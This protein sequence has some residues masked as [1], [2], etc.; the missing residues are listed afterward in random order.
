MVLIQRHNPRLRTRG[1]TKNA[2]ISTAQ[3]IRLAFWGL[4]VLSLLLA[5]YL[6][7][8]VGTASNPVNQTEGPPPVSAMNKPVKNNNNAGVVHMAHEPDHDHFPNHNNAPHAKPNLRNPLVN[9]QKIPAKRVHE[10]D[11]RDSKSMPHN[12]PA[13][14]HDHHDEEHEWAQQ[15]Q[16]QATPSPTQSP[17][18]KLPEKNPDPI[19]PKPDMSA[20]NAVVVD[21]QGS[22]PTHL[23]Y[24]K[25][26]EFERAHPAI[27]ESAAAAV[28]T[29]AAEHMQEMS[30]LAETPLQSC[31]TEDGTL[32]PLC[33]DSDT[34]LYAYN[35]ADFSRTICD[36]EVEPHKLV[37]LDS[38]TDHE[39]LLEPARHIL[40]R[41]VIPLNGQGMPPVQV[42]AHE[43]GAHT[44]KMQAV[45]CDV[46][47]EYD[48]SLM[49]DDPPRERYIH[50]E[51]WKILYDHPG[52][53]RNFDKTDWKRDIY[54]STVS[55]QSS[56]PVSTYDFEKYN[57]RQ[58]PVVDYNTAERA[59]S[60]F[61]D[62][63]CEAPGTRRHKWLYALQAVYPVH[64]YGKCQHNTDGDIS[65]MESRLELMRKDRL[66][67]AYEVSDG[68]DAFS[69]LTWEALQSGVVPVLV[70]PSNA[71][72]VL[73]PK[74]FIWFG[75]YNNW[76]KFSEEVVRVAD[77][78]ETWESYQEWR[79]DEAVVAAFE[80]RMNF[81]R[82][83]VECRTC[84]WAYAKM[85]GLNWDT[86]QQQIRPSTIQRDQVCVS[87][88]DPALIS[89]PFQEMWSGHVDE[90][91][92]HATECQNKAIVQE[93]TIEMD[94][95]KVTR[96][97]LHH[98]GVTDILLTELD[99]TNR[100]EPIVLRLKFEIKNFEGA[101]FPHP[102][103]QVKS[104]NH[105]LVSSAAMQDFST[106]ATVLADWKTTITSPEEGIMEVTL[107][108]SLE[109]TRRVR[110]ILEDVD[111]LYYKFTEFFPFTIGNKM[112]E[113]FVN[114]VEI[115]HAAP[116]R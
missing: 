70:G 89:K 113:D 11:E 62:E 32:A 95:Y 104:D 46:P 28:A 27:W 67:L 12:V 52:I 64:A 59:A 9:Q 39:C 66:V 5:V 54:Y 18:Q 50:G 42:V 33:K 40:P 37:K 93:A 8:R 112:T 16:D 41:D 2:S 116:K 73:P 55:R 108:K 97:V 77:N 107:P 58:A 80:K 99:V 111:T 47:C 14:E 15:Q 105:H 100:D 78:Q 83:S 49:F 36:I 87:T 74:S 103:A 35:N 85:Y 3:H 26:L 34:M 23:G 30:K 19:Q 86:E 51:S 25:D 98:D 57:F 115:Y 10:V 109:E 13:T 56:I 68:K 106:R 92:S 60:Y 21:K 76:D 88:Q 44:A 79:K 75:Y 114:P 31:T 63:K 96:H 91:Q 61:A 101:Y 1:K 20:A 7:R 17:I 53:V 45:T 72:Q 71:V 82:T 102:H 84:R 4:M 81:T 22:G 90:G 94:G 48:V 43:D 65:T 6:L 24:V 38:L 69:Q 29:K 110:V